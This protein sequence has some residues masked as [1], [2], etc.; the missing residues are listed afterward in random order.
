MKKTLILLTLITAPLFAHSNRSHTIQ[1]NIESLR[2]DASTTESTMLLLVIAQEVLAEVD[3]LATG[4]IPPRL[5]QLLDELL[6][7]YAL[8][9]V[10]TVKSYTTRDAHDAQQQLNNITTHL[11]TYSALHPHETTHAQLLNR[12]MHV[13]NQ[14]RDILLPHKQG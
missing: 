2:K 5:A 9:N 11:L 1:K 10:D 13:N 6:E 4:D 8:L 3:D 14:V 7:F 12:I